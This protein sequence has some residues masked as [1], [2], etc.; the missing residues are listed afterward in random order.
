MTSRPEMSLVLNGETVGMRERVN[1]TTTMFILPS[2]HRPAST[3]FCK[4]SGQGKVVNGLDLRA[5]RTYSNM[6]IDRIVNVKKN[7]KY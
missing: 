5:G 3:V 4:L 6:N 2:L 7:P 1:R